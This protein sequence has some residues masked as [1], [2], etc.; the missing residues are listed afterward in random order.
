MQSWI[1]EAA[2]TMV[3]QNIIG[4][5][6]FFCSMSGYGMLK[7]YDLLQISWIKTSLL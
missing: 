5:F 4:F 1:I 3:Y 6:K 7:E 2:R